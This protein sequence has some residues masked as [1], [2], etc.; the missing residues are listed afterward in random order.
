LGFQMGGHVPADHPT[1][2]GINNHRQVKKSRL[3]RDI[4]DISDPQRVRSGRREIPLDQVWDR[5]DIAIAVISATHNRSGPTAEKSRWTRSGT[6]WTSR[7]RRVVRVPLR[8]LTPSSPAARISRAT[9]FRPT[10]SP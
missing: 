4:G 7:S 2:E 9:R 3:G 8:R 1:A 10:Q 5:M 6:G